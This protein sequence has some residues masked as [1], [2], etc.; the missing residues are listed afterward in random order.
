MPQRFDPEGTRHKVPL[1]LGV[2]HPSKEMFIVANSNLPPNHSVRLEFHELEERYND[3]D[4]D[5]KPDE[6]MRYLQLFIWLFV[7]AKHK[8]VLGEEDYIEWTSISEDLL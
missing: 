6:W 4:C 3:N 7:T 1:V 2:K 8:S 5:L